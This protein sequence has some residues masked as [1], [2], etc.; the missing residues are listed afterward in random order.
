MAYELDGGERD[1]ASRLKV[2]VVRDAVTLCVPDGS[3]S[4]SG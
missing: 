3:A 4:T 1:P 2:R